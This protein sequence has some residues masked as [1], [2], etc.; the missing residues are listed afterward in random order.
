MTTASNSLRE[1]ISFFTD[2]PV[3][4]DKLW[5]AQQQALD[6]V[7]YS[8]ELWDDIFCYL[9]GHPPTNPETI[10]EVDDDER[11]GIHD[12]LWKELFGELRML[13]IMRVFLRRISF[14]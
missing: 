8:A 2:N 12:P 11:P 10:R 1:M 13:F 6:T 5:R 14:H 7:T 3:W 4:F 9:Y